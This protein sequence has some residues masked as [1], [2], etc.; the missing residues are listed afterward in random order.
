MSRSRLVEGTHRKLPRSRRSSWGRTGKYENFSGESL[1][2]LSQVG[3]RP[4]AGTLSEQCA[5]EQ[6]TKY[7]VRERNV[8]SST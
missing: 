2:F 3:Q 8:S 5:L 7:W 1:S 4:L 6:Q